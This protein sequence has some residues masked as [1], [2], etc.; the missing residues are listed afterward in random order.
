LNGCS[1]VELQSNKTRIEVE[2]YSRNYSAAHQSI[3]TMCSIVHQRRTT[4]VTDADPL[5]QWRI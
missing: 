3:D 1:A 2:S 5:A 4:A